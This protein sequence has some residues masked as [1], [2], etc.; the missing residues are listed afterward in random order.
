MLSSRRA[1]A[2]DSFP[3]SPQAGQAPAQTGHSPGPCW[4]RPGEDLTDETL[5]PNLASQAAA[6]GEEVDGRM[7]SRCSVQAFP[8]AARTYLCTKTHA[9]SGRRVRAHTCAARLL[10]GSCRKVSVPC[11]RKSQPALKPRGLGPRKAAPESAASRPCCCQN[12]IK[13]EVSGEIQAHFSR[14]LTSL[15]PGPTGFARGLHNP[16]TQR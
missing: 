5:R 3:E 9:P 11:L 1:C 2:G 6:L 12:R 4:E 8:K 13:R 7:G 15:S 16:P 14:G 10:P